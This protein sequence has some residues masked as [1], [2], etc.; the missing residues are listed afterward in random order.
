[1]TE[2]ITYSMSIK[3]VKP[4]GNF[5]SGLFSPKNPDKYIGDLHKIICRSSWE[6]RFCN[7]CDGNDSV[8]KWSSEPTA[9]RYYNPLDKK[10]HD[11]YVDFYIKVLKEDGE[12]EEWILEV[13]PESQTIKPVYEGKNMTTEKL[14]SY[15]HKMQVYIV[16]QAKFKYAK[17][18]AEKRGFR[19]GIVDENFLFRGK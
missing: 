2:A 6:F 1:M 8:I 4:N 7:Y 14:R 5:R 16:N 12:E 10:E 18:W 3:K 11:Y 15:N 17:A 13:K 19:F 9:I